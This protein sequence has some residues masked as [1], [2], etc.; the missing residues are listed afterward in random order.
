MQPG[1]R[2]LVHRQDSDFPMGGQPMNQKSWRK[3]SVLTLVP[4]TLKVFPR[5]FLQVGS[6]LRWHMHH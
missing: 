4:T 3:T 2:G 5:Q 6:S 1:Q